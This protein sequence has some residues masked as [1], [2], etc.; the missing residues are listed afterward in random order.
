M[1][2]STLDRQIEQRLNDSGARYTTGRR[3][4][5]EALTRAEG[6]LSAAE[7]HDI[8]GPAMPLSS[9]YRSLTVLEASGVVTPHYGQ[10]VTRYELA[11]W[12]TGHHHHLVC[13]ECGA[14]D[15]IELP[16]SLESKVS[17]LVSEIGR[18]SGFRPTDHTLEIEGQCSR[19]A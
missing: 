14:V 11:E 15:D 2:T 12:I 13:I 16:G 7:V 1:T 8:L 18:S 17:S 19:C 4:V 10:G 3:N 5:I 6:P 9:L